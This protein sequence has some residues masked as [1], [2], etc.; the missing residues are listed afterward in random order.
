[1]IWWIVQGWLHQAETGSLGVHI[2][3]D[4]ELLEPVFRTLAGLGLLH[5]KAIPRKVKSL[6]YIVVLTCKDYM[7]DL[8]VMMQVQ[9]SRILYWGVEPWNWQLL[10]ACSKQE[11]AEAL[12]IPAEYAINSVVSLGYPAETPIAEDSEQTTRYYKD[13][14][15]VLHVPKRPLKSILY[16]DKEYTQEE[17]NE[18]R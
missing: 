15:G 16:V 14:S 10:A 13:K 5:L 1:M 18:K 4:E 6:A 3:Q 11:L 7:D 2:V 12:E 17:D 9:L 8:P